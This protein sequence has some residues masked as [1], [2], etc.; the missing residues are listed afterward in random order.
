MSQPFTPLVAGLP[1]TIPFVGPEAIQRRSKQT[2]KARI[3]ANESAFGISPAAAT[4]MQAEIARVAWYADP[5]GFELRTAIA[6]RFKVELDEVCLG[7]GVDELLGLL[8]RTVVEPGVHV[9]TSLG[10]YPTFNYHVDGFGGTLHKVPYRDD[11]IDLQ[12]VAA[13]AHEH[14]AALVYLANPDNP[15]GTWHDANAVGSF[16]AALPE[17]CLLVYDEAYIEFAPDSV[18]MNVDTKDA[19][20][21]RM[22][23]FSKAHGMAGAR[24]GYAIAAKPVIQA[25]NKVRNH[26]GMNRIAVAGA[27]AS[28]NDQAFV[29][30][31]V[32][33]VAEG[34]EEYEA[35]AE[36]LGL[37]ALESATNFV[38][39]DVGDGDR[40]RAIL[41]ALE[42]RGVFIRMPS[43]APLDR[44]IRVSVG[45]PEER[46]IFAEQFGQVLQ[47]R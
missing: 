36:R 3:G 26:F 6:D 37:S 8:V 23:T 47:S 15:M 33:R 32:A 43:V 14:H 13:A 1:A 42:A 4:A 30:D 35:L 22:R 45:L 25:L 11:H 40:A 34:R 44:C 16:K 18:Q 20:A 19:R 29:A 9:V 10:A 41:T 24:V 38:A 28:F 31:V 27:L 21:V 5:E 2:F 39:I 46:A 7:A 17:N 12:A